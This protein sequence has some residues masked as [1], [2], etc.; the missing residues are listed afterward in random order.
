MMEIIRDVNE[1]DN[2][3]SRD[4]IGNSKYFAEQRSF[5]RN[6]ATYSLADKKIQLQKWSEAK[7]YFA[8]MGGVPVSWNKPKNT[9]AIDCSDSH[10]LII[11]PTGS[12]KS[13][14]VVMPT[15]KVLTEAKENMIISDPKAEIYNRT[16]Q[17]L[18]EKGYK[19]YVL[20]LR[21]PEY[22]SAW[23]PLTIPYKFYCD[24]NIDRAYE[25]V[26][27]IAINLVALDGASQDPFW[28]NSA[29][30]LFFGLTILLFKYCKDY[31][32]DERYVHIG[33]VFRLRNIMCSGNTVKVQNSPLWNYAKTD[34]FIT[35]SL[36][37]TIETANDT[38]AGILSVFDQKM[39]AFAIQPN[40]LNML[41]SNDI[42]LDEIEEKPTAIFL[43]MP[44]EKTSYHGLVSLFIK[45]SY[46]YIIFKVQSRLALENQM[47]H[48][49]VNYILDEFSSLPQI[50]DFP[51]MITAARSRNIRFNIVVQS[52]HQLQLRYAEEADTIQ[53]NCNNWIFLSSKELKLLQELSTLCGEKYD[54]RGSRP[55]LPIDK[56]QRLNKFKG[57]ALILSGRHKPYIARLADI[58]EYDKE[59]FII[60]PLKKRKNTKKDIK[61]EFDLP[62]KY[63]N[64]LYSELKNIHI[65]NFHNII[66][67]YQ[68]MDNKEGE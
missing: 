28:D 56:L 13:R 64:S 52:K 5:E 60:L 26:N 32:I 16:A 36:I 6:F 51:A 49:R 8:G 42:T 11:G 30:T 7:K 37:G 62:D 31:N 33:N 63:N 66:E 1:Y 41:S 35:S 12:K 46:E 19:T 68:K 34:D 10:T 22:G 2:I 17:G 9:V 38:R 48:I 23:N 58:N 29:G 54:G 39:R 4:V 15:V 65:N 3:S 55:I 61:L 27:D 67:K 25:F 24:G 43:I 53:A 18:M 50:K 47:R 21:D 14:L 59:K 40:L 44:D 45:Q 57:E 20:N